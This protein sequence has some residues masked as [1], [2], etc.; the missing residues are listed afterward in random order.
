MEMDP[1]TAAHETQSYLESLVGRVAGDLISI[2]FRPNQVTD[3]GLIFPRKRDG[4]LRISEQEPKHLFLQ[5]ARADGRFCYSVETPTTQ[6][7]CQKGTSGMSARVDLTLVGRPEQPSVNIELKAHNCGTE[8]IRKDLEKLVRENTMG[9]WFHTLEKGDRF[10]V[11]SFLGTFR[12]AF[13]QLS[14][15]LGASNTSYLISICSLEARLLY[16]RWLV[17]TGNL[18]LNLAAIDSAFQEHG[19]SSGAWH[20][21]RFGSDAPG[22]EPDAIGACGG[23]SAYHRGKGLREGFFIYAPNI[24]NDTYMHLSGRGGS[25][26]IRNFY[27]TKAAKASEFRVPGYPTLKSLRESGVV[28]KWLSVTAEDSHH[29][30]IDQPGYWYERILQINQQAFAKEDASGNLSHS[31]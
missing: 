25:Y 1:S 28:A 22:N 30:I 11:Q 24:A 14:A 29:N 23:P 21:I 8:N 19:L 6:T 13:G 5:N 31:A 26:R 4:S 12:T 16:W 15:Y 3:H 10:Q 17:L 20:M 18:D 7:Y 27:R 9:V 2:Y